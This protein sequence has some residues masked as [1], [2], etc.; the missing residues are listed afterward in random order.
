[1]EKQKL[2][3]VKILQGFTIC[4]PTGVEHDHSVPLHNSISIRKFVFFCNDL[5]ILLYKFHYWD[6]IYF[7]TTEVLGNYLFHSSCVVKYYQITI[8]ETSNMLFFC[9]IEKKNQKQQDSA[10]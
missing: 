6:I 8:K 3:E 1:M 9:L 2:K 5:I 10:T 4:F 7:I